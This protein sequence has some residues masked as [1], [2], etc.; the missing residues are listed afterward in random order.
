MYFDPRA[1]VVPR[2][3]TLAAPHHPVVS[4]LLRLSLIFPFWHPLYAPYTVGHPSFS[5]IRGINGDHTDRDCNLVS[6]HYSPGH[7]RPFYRRT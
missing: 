4:A 6:Y 3:A 1:R 7:T 2:S 5:H